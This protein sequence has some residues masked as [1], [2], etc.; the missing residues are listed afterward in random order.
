MWGRARARTPGTALRGAVLPNIMDTNPHK[1]SKNL[2]ELAAITTLQPPFTSLHSCPCNHQ[3]GPVKK[4]EVIDGSTSSYA[5]I[6]FRR[7]VLEVLLPE[8]PDYFTAN[9][10]N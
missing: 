3:P 7:Q 4:S 9:N 10:L 2:V 1:L 5:G 6:M 8:C